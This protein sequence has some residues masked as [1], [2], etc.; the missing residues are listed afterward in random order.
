MATDRGKE[1]PGLSQRKEHLLHA[2]YYLQVEHHV[3]SVPVDH[4]EVLRHNSGALEALADEGL[5]QV[6]K[7]QARLT[8]A[9][10]QR[11]RDV[12]RRHRLAERLM[13][14]VLGMP[15]DRGDYIAG[16]MEHIVSPELTDSICTLLGHPTECPH[17][18]PIPPGRCCEQRA[19]AVEAAV[20]PLSQMRA[21]EKGR[22]AY[23]SASGLHAAAPGRPR[24]SA[25]GRGRR[26][27][28]GG[29]PP[30]KGGGRRRIAQLTALGLFPGE[31]IEVLQTSPA[32]V[33]RIGGTT[34]AV[35]EDVASS[36]RVRRSAGD[37]GAPS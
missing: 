36:I 12:V 9:G 13:T 33:V 20:V 27:G 28:R 6:Q 21:G 1:S 3:P 23:L 32:F 15:A 4:P 22:I 5:V 26:R 29:P 37:A 16:E 30:G 25:L 14:D 7:G 31:D 19:R 18:N 17:G 35:D 2:L 34:L 8:G 10:Q 11:A 24:R